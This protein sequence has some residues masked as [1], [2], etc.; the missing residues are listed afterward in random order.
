M[1]K[2]A[3]KDGIQ[4]L[5]KLSDRLNDLEKRYEQERECLIKYYC[6]QTG[7]KELDGQNEERSGLYVCLNDVN[8]VNG[9]AL[10]TAYDENQNAFKHIIDEHFSICTYTWAMDDF[11]KRV[12]DIRYISND[13]DEAILKIA[14]FERGRCVNFYKICFNDDIYVIVLNFEEGR[15]IWKNTPEGLELQ[16]I[17]DE[18]HKAKVKRRSLAPSAL[19]KRQ[20]KE[21]INRHK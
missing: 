10:V 14:D 13:K 19:C 11:R 16:R 3:I 21:I 2:D 5:K 20:K 15:E 9:F 18:N 17:M 12:Y 4:N 1:E 8:F 6:E 7:L